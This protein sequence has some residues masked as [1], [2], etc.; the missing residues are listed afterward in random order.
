MK[1]IFTLLLGTI[2]S[3][4]LFAYDGTRLTV[5][6][7]SNMKMTVEIDGRRYN[8]DRSKTLSLRDLSAGRHTIRIYHERRNNSIFNRNRQEVIYNQTFHLRR[9]YHLD[10]TINRF[11]RVMVDER[12]IDR[13]DDWYDDDDNWDR[14]NRHWETDDRRNDNRDDSYRRQMSDYDFNQAKETLRREWVENTKLSLAKQII[15]RNYMSAQQI[16]EMLQMFSFENNKLDLAKYAYGRA[17]DR[18][19]YHIVNDVFAYSNSRDE[20]ARYIRDYR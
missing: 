13:N 9:D 1:R 11:G 19:N 10:I 15:D 2:F 8:M 5:N 16:K 4:A 14:N 12:R 20:L 18:R 17:V 7:V 6:T 3:L